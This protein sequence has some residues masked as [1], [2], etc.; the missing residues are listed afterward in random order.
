[1]WWAT[2]RT[3]PLLV[4]LPALNLAAVLFFADAPGARSG[5]LPSRFQ[6]SGSDRWQLALLVVGL[7]L[8]YGAALTSLGLALATGVSRP[9]RATAWCVT[10]FVFITVVPLAAGAIVTSHH[11]RDQEFAWFGVA[12][13][14]WG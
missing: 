3:V 12:C 7:T 6:S 8:A 13:P 9:G 4:A 14:F 1:K 10:A 11:G 5:G 2:F